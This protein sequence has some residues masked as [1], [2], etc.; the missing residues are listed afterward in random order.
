[1]ESDKYSI[2]IASREHFSEMFYALNGGVEVPHV[3]RSAV[4][5]VVEARGV[6]APDCVG[7]VREPDVDAS[8]AG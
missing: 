3:A 5:V 6:F 2:G 7:D 1:M 8:C 4:E